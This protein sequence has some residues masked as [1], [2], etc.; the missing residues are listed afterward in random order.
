M[1]LK[2]AMVYFS[3]VLFQAALYTFLP[4][5]GKGQ[6][7]PAGQLLEYNV[8]G[9]LA[10]QTTVTLAVAGCLAGVL[11]PSL[12]T[13]NWEGMIVTMNIYGYLLSIAAYL[14]AHIAPT[15]PQDRKFSGSALYDFYMGIELNPRFTRTGSWDWKLFHNG[16]PGIIG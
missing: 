13:D 2:A 4:G 15:H 16:R 5:K 1:S 9:L 14:K 10:W 6:L 11:D 8:N 3:W 7:T 12:L